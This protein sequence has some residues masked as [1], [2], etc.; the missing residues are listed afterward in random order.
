MEQ[1]RAKDD[2]AFRALGQ[3]GSFTPYT[4]P[5]AHVCTI[6]GMSVVA[7]PPGPVELD[8]R[9]VPFFIN[10]APSVQ[11]S[12]L[13]R[14]NLN[15][16]DIRHRSHLPRRPALDVY[17]GGSHHEIVAANSDWELLIQVDDGRLPA[18]AAEDWD[19]RLE[20]TFD[21][22][23]L[24]DPVALQLSR[25]ALDHLRRGDPDRLYV[26]GLAIALTARAVGLATKRGPCAPTGGT[27]ARIARAVD[28]IEAHLSDDL[29]VA[30]IASEAAM[31]PSWFAACFK[32]QI[33]QPVHAYVMARRC[34]RARLL[35]AERRL[36]LAQVAAACGFAHQAHM[37][38]AFKARFGTTPKEARTSFSS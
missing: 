14:L 21:M 7:L 23:S 29:S 37:G 2:H 1:G 6:S 17:A 9:D 15:G 30:L 10:V 22:A 26:E 13:H 19:D 38:R 12:A 32:D 20:D 28:Y 31:S 35:I 24:M 36:P 11:P 33:G 25:L 18:L 8:M 34:E 3:T 27:D 5:R 4:S 16:R